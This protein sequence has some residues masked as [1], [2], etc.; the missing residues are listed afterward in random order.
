[1]SL[2]IKTRVCNCFVISSFSPGGGCWTI[3]SQKGAEVTM[4]GTSQQRRSFKESGNKM[5]TELERSS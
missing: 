1:M 5:D 3:S 2:E 4:N